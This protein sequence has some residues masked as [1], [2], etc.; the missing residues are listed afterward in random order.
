MGLS[1]A[2]T[3]SLSIW[4]RACTRST[5]GFRTELVSELLA[6]LAGSKSPSSQNHS[7]DTCS[8]PSA[9]L[10]GPY[11]FLWDSLCLPS[12]TVEKT[13]VTG[14]SLHGKS[15]WAV[16]EMGLKGLCSLGTSNLMKMEVYLLLKSILR[17]KA[18]RRAALALDY[19]RD[20]EGWY[21]SHPVP[22][23]DSQGQP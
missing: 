5:G 16:P 19:Q 12:R 3:R 1:M 13:S 14:Q 6:L 4:S 9:L 10:H 20:Q 23:T 11:F 21:T 7:Q 2:L 22:Y 17:K 15:C 18:L 8:Q